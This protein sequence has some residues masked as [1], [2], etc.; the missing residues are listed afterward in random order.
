MAAKSDRTGEKSRPPDH[1]AGLAVARK[2]QP[3]RPIHLRLPAFALRLEPLDHVGVET[4]GDAGLPP[5]TRNEIDIDRAFE[6]HF[7]NVAEIDFIVG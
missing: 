6:F 7:W 4:D 2:V 3:Q 1:R 5:G